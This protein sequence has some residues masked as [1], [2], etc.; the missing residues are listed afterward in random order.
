MAPITN[1]AFQL[2]RLVQL[3]CGVLPNAVLALSKANL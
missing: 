3:F 2:N 1:R